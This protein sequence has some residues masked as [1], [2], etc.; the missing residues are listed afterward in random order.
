MFVSLLTCCLLNI[1]TTVKL[2][3]RCNDHNARL[4]VRDVQP[5]EDT[6]PLPEGLPKARCRGLARLHVVV[7]QHHLAPSS[8]H[9]PA[10]LLQQHRSVNMF[11]FYSKLKEG[12]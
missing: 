9:A 8:Q 1:W 5:R 7:R 2:Y 11:F 4:P 6:A 3:F 10:E 12:F